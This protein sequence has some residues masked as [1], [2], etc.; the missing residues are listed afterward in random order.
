MVI[1]TK[2][3]QA[4]LGIIIS[5]T[6][7]M[8]SMFALDSRWA[9]AEELADVRVHMQQIMERLDQKIEMDRAN[10]LRLWMVQMDIEYGSDKRQWS[11]V[12]LESYLGM[13]TEY[14]RIMAKYGVEK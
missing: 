12:A 13:K 10:Q 8:G 6:I 11:N 14:D 2:K 5:L 3:V 4:V 7:I 1:T 9:K